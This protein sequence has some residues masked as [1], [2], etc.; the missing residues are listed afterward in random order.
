MAGR[1]QVLLQVVH[2]FIASGA[3]FFEVP[4][5]LHRKFVGFR[6]AP[7]GTSG[8]VHCPPSALASADQELLIILEII[9]LFTTRK[10]IACGYLGM[11]LRDHNADATFGDHGEG[12]H[13][14]IELPEPHQE[15]EAGGE[16]L[17]MEPCFPLCDK[18]AT[19]GH[20]LARAEQ[21]EL[22]RYQTHPALKY[23]HNAEENAQNLLLKVGTDDQG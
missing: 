9:A 10:N 12:L 1:E 23:D 21:H 8:D 15:V 7:V 5:S 18:D 11:F 6:T 13:G 17:R 22:L 4:Q 19:V 16:D 20:F 3:R 2:A 14:R